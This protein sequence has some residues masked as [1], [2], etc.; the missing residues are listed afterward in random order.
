MT[1][2]GIPIINPDNPNP[3]DLSAAPA[4]PYLFDRLEGADYP[5]FWGLTNDMLG[6]FMDPYDFELAEAGPYVEEPPGDHYEETN[7]IG[8][9][10]W[11]T[12]EAEFLEILSRRPVP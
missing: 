12:V 3:P 11:P 5:M 4:G 7:S 9:A 10:G 2:A 1:P 6:Y 8:M